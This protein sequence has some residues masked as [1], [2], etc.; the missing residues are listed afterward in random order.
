LRVAVRAQ[1]PQVLLAVIGRVTVDVVDFKN[2]R[3]SVPLR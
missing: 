3:F 2:K 1:K